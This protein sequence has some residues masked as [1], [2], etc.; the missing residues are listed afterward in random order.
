MPEDTPPGT[1]TDWQT[2]EGEEEEEQWT[3]EGEHEDTMEWA[4]ESG[5]IYLLR[6]KRTV[7]ARNAP[8]AAVNATQGAMQQFRSIPNSHPKG[9]GKGEMSCLRC[10]QPG[11]F[12]R[13]CPNHSDKI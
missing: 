4:D 1:T 3:E 8:G 12:W 2:T 13:Q 10:G 5:E 6:P 11:R 9:K 7:K